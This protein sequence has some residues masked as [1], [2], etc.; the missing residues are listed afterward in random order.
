MKG[1]Q[2]AFFMLQLVIIS[3]CISNIKLFHMLNVSFPLEI[4]YCIHHYFFISYH[5]YK[6]LPGIDKL[7]SDQKAT[8]NFAHNLVQLDMTEM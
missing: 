5:S 4:H 7:C 2:K 1:G 6:S 3:D 8:V